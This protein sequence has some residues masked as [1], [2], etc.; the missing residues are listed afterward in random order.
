[1]TLTYSRND[2]DLINRWLAARDAEKKS[3]R[4]YYGDRPC[5]PAEALL[6][7]CRRIFSKPTKTKPKA[8]ARRVMQGKSRLRNRI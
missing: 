3:V 8:R 7:V 2:V 6:A 4:A 5:L 1:M